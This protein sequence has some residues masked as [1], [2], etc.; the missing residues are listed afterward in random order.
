MRSEN[1][2]RNLYNTNRAPHYHLYTIHNKIN[3]LKI[4]IQSK[5]F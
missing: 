3:G 1:I 5:V 4:I 2:E